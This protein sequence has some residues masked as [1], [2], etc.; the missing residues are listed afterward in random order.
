MPMRVAALPQAEL[1]RRAKGFAEAG[2]R[3][4]MRSAEV[5][6]LRLIDGTGV[7]GHRADRNGRFCR[8]ADREAGP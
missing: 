6:R 2:R 5:G 1:D 3:T 7:G 8:R 4:R